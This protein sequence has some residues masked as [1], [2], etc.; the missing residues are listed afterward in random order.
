MYKIEA[1]ILKMFIII[2]IILHS[3]TCHAYWLLYVTPIFLPHLPFHPLHKYLSD[4]FVLFVLI[5]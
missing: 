5:D 2:I 4:M 1:G 3:H